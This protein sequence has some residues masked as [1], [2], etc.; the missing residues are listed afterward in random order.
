MIKTK[1]TGGEGYYTED[2]CPEDLCFCG[3]GLHGGLCLSCGL[4]VWWCRDNKICK[5]L[6]RSK[7]GEVA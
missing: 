2:N 6:E 3:R 5:P 4:S 1:S 7:Q